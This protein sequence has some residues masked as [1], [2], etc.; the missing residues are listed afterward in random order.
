M[1]SSAIDMTLVDLLATLDRLRV[2]HA[3]DKD[4]IVLRKALPQ[5]WPL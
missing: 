1:V 5:D 3:Q 2:E 4:Y